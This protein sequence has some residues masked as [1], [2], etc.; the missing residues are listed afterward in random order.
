MHAIGA[1]QKSGE[2]KN[3]KPV[4]ATQRGVRSPLAA[5]SAP[6]G[7]PLD[8]RGPNARA[9]TSCL[10]N[11]PVVPHLCPSPPAATLGPLQ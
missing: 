4:M 2:C 10:V 7:S 11:L 5:P 3:L 9:G 6:S 8:P 1:A